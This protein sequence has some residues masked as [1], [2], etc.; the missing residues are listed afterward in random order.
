MTSRVDVLYNDNYLIGSNLNISR[1]N[2]DY[3]I[4]CPSAFNLGPSLD[5]DTY[6]DDPDGCRG[7][8]CIECWDQPYK[9]K[10]EKQ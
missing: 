7:I 5:E 6:Q 8:T 10:K 2:K 1:V 9:E 4:W 3:I